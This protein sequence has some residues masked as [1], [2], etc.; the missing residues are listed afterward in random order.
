MFD[1]LE[2]APPD[3][4]LGLSEAVRKDPNPN[5]IDL[6]VGNYVGEAGTT[7]IFS[8]VKKA[9]HG[10]LEGETTKRYLPI[11]GSPAYSRAVQ[12]MALGPGHEALASR[13]AATAHTPGGTGALRVGADFL[14]KVRPSARLWVSDPT[15]PN[16]LGVFGAAGF[17]ISSY[18]Y[19]DAKAKCLDF[20]RMLAALGEI[21]RGDVLLLH[22]SCHNPTGMDP[23]PQQWRRIAEVAAERSLPAFFDLA[24][25]GFGQGLEEDAASV[26]A[27]ATAGREML[28]A[29]SYSKN[30][31]LYCE[32][33]GALTVIAS[34]PEAAE[35]AL[36]HVRIAI[37][38]NYSNPPAHGAA[39]VVK[40]LGDCDLRK[41]WEEE[42]TA[43]R[44]R[45]QE[46]RRLF[47]ET[48]KTKGVARDFSFITRQNG[49][50]SLSGLTKEQVETL[51][52]R[53]SIYIV[54]SGRINVAGM[55]RA[56]MDRLCEAIA[57][58]LQQ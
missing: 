35:K 47:V 1:E 43:V 38:A 15:W 26:R 19:Y 9:E 36:S 6:G 27:F 34:S 12:E 33:V 49:M 10:I 3:P 2:M 40:I 48:L 21:P 7:P 18:P 37:R 39:I 56:N 51:R 28:I 17:E 46:M 44:G 57:R 16:H 54:G 13:R 31:G 30:F 50:F 25:Q 4:I 11:D 8:A 22:G 5:K 52:S 58:V 45:I 32:R 53:D 20:D 14:R 23:T 29:S 41:E 24:Y 42:L 55:T